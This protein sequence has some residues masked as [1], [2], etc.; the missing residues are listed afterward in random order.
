MD[1]LK[2][3]LKMDP[4]ERPWCSQ[5]LKHDFFKKDNFG[6]KFAQE[7]KAKITRENCR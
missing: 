2:L 7:L 4:V 1:I 5:L 3:C 6:E